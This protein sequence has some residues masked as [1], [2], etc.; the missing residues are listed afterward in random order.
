MAR[1]V[2]LP[3]RDPDW[4]RTRVP[5]DGTVQQ[6]GL[7]TRR[8]R[9]PVDGPGM[10]GKRLLLFTDLHWS[11]RTATGAEALIDAVNGAKADW[12]AFGGDLTR[13][14]EH[15]GAA[16]AILGRMS[17]RRACLATL[18]N[19]ERSHRWMHE[20]RWRR[21]FGEAGFRLLVNEAWEDPDPEG[22][23]FVGM[24][25]FR[26]GDGHITDGPVR[27]SGTRVVIRIAHCPDAVG[28]T[29]G[30]DL[31]HLVLCGH[32]HAGQIRMPG[33]G[34]VYTSSYYGKAFEYGWHRR[35]SDGTWLYVSA[36]IGCTGSRL[37]RRR[38]H[39]PP[40]VVVIE[41][42]PS[43]DGQTARQTEGPS[44]L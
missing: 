29:T 13:H 39:C 12:V 20:D 17:A 19:W 5:E 44:C 31:G 14:L 11:Q 25:D 8:F 16:I 21:L 23:V 3:V 30:I 38:I 2:L 27:S 41:F 35:T 22:P 32:T 43:T 34:A 40:E 36:G 10:A 42:V 24:D 1:M 4:R 33:F 15:A 7:M 37:F 28:K 18:G 6:D 9:F 26:L